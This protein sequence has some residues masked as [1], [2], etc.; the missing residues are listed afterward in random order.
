M[1]EALWKLWFLLSELSETG[2]QITRNDLN[3]AAPIHPAPYQPNVYFIQIP[4]NRIVNVAM[5]AMRGLYNVGVKSGFIIG[6][7]L[8][9]DGINRLY[10]FVHCTHNTYTSHAC[11]R[12]KVSVNEMKELIPITEEENIAFRFFEPF[13]PESDIYRAEVIE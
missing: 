13:E 8:I 1:G 4:S 9:P 2:H 10:P 7:I 6:V 5:C 11:V 3:D 12:V